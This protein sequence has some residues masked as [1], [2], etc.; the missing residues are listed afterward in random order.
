[1][2][3][4]FGIYLTLAIVVVFGLSPRATAEYRSYD[5]TGNNLANSNWGAAGSTLTRISTAAYADGISNPRGMG[6]PTL[7]N[8]RAISNMVVAQ[9][10]MFPNTH[11]MTD[12][13]FQWGQFVDH[14]LDLTNLASPVESYNVAIPAGDPIF[15]PGN[16]GT[17]VMSFQRSKYDPATGDSLGNPR[18]QI[19]DITSYLDASNVYGSDEIR[20]TTLRTLSGG[21]MKTSAGNLLPLNTFGL[22]NGTGGPADPTQFY[23]AGDVRANEQVG[24]TAVH[25]LFVREHNRLADDIAAANPT[26]TDE[27]IYQRAR[28]L[29]GGQIQVITYNEFLPALLGPHAP[30]IGS[31]YDANVNASVL[32]EFSTALYRV[33]HTMLSPN[34]QRMLND[35]SEAAGGPMPLRDAFFVPQNLAPT[36]EIDCFLKGLASQQQQEVDMHI[37]DDVRNF[38][39]GEPIPGGFDLATLNIQ[40][41]RD[42]GLADYNSLRVAFGL[43]AVTSFADIT[44]APDVQA[45]LAAL[46]TDVNQ[47]DAWVGALSEDHLAGSAAGPLITAGLAAQFT[48]TR[49]GDRLWFARDDELSADDVDWLM[50]RRLSDVILAN[51]S[52]TNLQGNVFF[53]AVPEPASVFL[54][55]AAAVG[56]TL[57]GR[58]RRGR[59]IG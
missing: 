4:N 6:D 41:G 44:S 59:K 56:L 33:G 16:T 51:T 36:G 30:G 1:M 27:Q 8:P 31:A 43:P 22:P 21:Q 37:V 23:V 26:W 58:P 18:Q 53:M 57:S 25:T 49:D 11:E 7:P 52:L 47:I 46:Y 20:A 35:G 32:T 48:N 24:L 15:D 5:G 42:H 40:R 14:D 28:K 19:N 10:S 39:F 29:V 9:T 50:S 38:L 34:L 45:G 12:W 55:A 2:L 54:L 13:V 3:R 17:Q